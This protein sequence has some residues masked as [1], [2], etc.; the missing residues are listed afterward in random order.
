VVTG[1]NLYSYENAEGIDGSGQYVA[2]GFGGG[3]AWN[4]L[5]SIDEMVTAAGGT[6][7]L[8]IVHENETFRRH[9][10]WRGSDGL[11]VA[12]LHLAPGVASRI[13]K[14]KQP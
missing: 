6:E 2:I 4:N 1:D 9:P 5:L 8:V 12:E 11:A 10:S 7:R 3:S 14:G 13:P